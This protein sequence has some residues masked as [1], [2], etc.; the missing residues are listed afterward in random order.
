MVN[1]FRREMPRPIVGFGHSMG[2]S[3]MLDLALMHPRLLTSVIAIEPTA[4]SNQKGGSWPGVASITFR[5]DRWRSADDAIDYFRKAP[6]HKRWNSRVLELYRQYGLKHESPNTEV[7]APGSQTILKTSKHQEAL[8]FARASFPASP[9]HGLDTIEFDRENH[10]EIVGVE[11]DPKAPMYRPES[12]TIFKQLPSL[13]P[14]CFYIYGKDSTFSANLPWKRKEKMQVTGIGPG[15][16]G[17]DP[18]GRVEEMDLPGSHFFPFEIPD[19]L[20]QAV[21][22]WLDAEMTKW[23]EAEA[24]HSDAWSAVPVEKRGAVSDEWVYWTKRLFKT[25]AK[26]AD[27]TAGKSKL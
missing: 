18:E 27:G 4:G 9:D 20:G 21:G 6:I 17:G 16:S 2:G 24:A 15:G 12:T 13:R 14:S 25:P 10:P 1:Q 7:D 23:R 11:T 3:V 22:V 19:E 26:G 8:N 5:K